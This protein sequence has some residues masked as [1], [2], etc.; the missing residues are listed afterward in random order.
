MAEVKKLPKEFAESRDVN[1]ALPRSQNGSSPQHLLVTLLGDLWYEGNEAIPASVLIA[2]LAEFDIS[3][4]AARAAINRLVRRGILASTRTGR[5]ARYLLTDRAHAI[6]RRGLADIGKS[7]TQTPPWDGRWTLAAFSIPEERRD[8]RSTLRNRLRWLGMAPLFDAQWVSSRADPTE[9]ADVFEELGIPTFSVFRG[10]I[11]ASSGV[12]PIAAWDL[13][14]IGAAYAQ[15]QERYEPQL[16]RLREGRFVIAD[17]LVERTR[18]MDEWRTFLTLD[19]K[20]PD[21]LVPADWPRALARSTFLALYDELG[22]LALIRARRI[23]AEIDPELADRLNLHSLS[24]H[25]IEHV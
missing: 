18:L 1:P 16:Q 23:V 19:P 7:A 2:V 10:E 11:D 13:D 20:L 4:P 9:I 22:E 12:T 3:K 14:R 17:A 8:L 21:E 6:L 15:F 25:T 5:E 24:S